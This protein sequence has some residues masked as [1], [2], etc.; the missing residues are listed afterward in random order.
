[1][2]RIYIKKEIA[3]DI[4]Q[5][6][7]DHAIAGQ[8]SVVEGK[9]G[10]PIINV[11]NQ[12]AHAEISLYGG[13][14]LSYTSHNNHE[15]LFLSER[16]YYQSGKAIKGGIP[17]CWPWFGADPSGKG[18]PAHGFARNQFW[19][20]L[21]TKSLNDSETKVI[22]GLYDSADT[23]KLWPY[24]FELKLEITISDSLKLKLIT[25]N[26]GDKDFSITQ[27]LHT[28]F[29]VDNIENTIV[30]GLENKQYLDKASIAQAEE[31]LQ[32]GDITIN[33]EVDRIYL[34]VPDELNIKDKEAKHEINIQTNG[35]RTAIVWN[36]WSEIAKKMGDLEDKDYKHF[37]CVETANAAEDII[38]IAAGD[39]F[40]LTAKYRIN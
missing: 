11:N 24:S 28:Y 4:S 31:M 36:P 1:M 29:A 32:S 16:A 40:S 8:V 26:T 10:F 35:N 18:L 21:E 13:Q 15:L 3:L 17:I 34:D 39:S 38:H 5:L 25:N 22:L 7:T 20:V 2:S 30:C 9:G 19:Q 33:E 12:L 23:L 37:V 14:V 27:A 6:N